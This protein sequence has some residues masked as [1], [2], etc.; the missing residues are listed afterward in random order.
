MEEFMVSIDGYGTS[1]TEPREVLVALTA[2]SLY[3][4]EDQMEQTDQLQLQ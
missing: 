3:F 2:L 1:D 4:S